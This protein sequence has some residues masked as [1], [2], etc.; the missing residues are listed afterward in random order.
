MEDL[1]S[2]AMM[3]IATAIGN[4]ISILLLRDRGKDRPKC[5]NHFRR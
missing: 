5:G 2:L 1:K 3:V 4:V